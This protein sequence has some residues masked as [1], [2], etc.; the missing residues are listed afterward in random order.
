M[1][2]LSGV[3]HSVFLTLMLEACILQE[4]YPVSVKKSDSE[5]GSPWERE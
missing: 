2:L 4:K 1:R 3:V 5:G